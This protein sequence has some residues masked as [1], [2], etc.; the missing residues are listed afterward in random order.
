MKQLQFHRLSE[1]FPMM[2]GEAFESLVADTK[3]RGLLHPIVLHNGKILDGRNRYRACIQADVPIRVEN[4][5]GP[6]PVGFVIASNL[7]RRHLNES[8]RAMVA[9]KLATMP[10]GGSNRPDGLLTQQVTAS[11]LNTSTRSIRRATAV[12]IKGTPE[13]IHRVERGDITVATAAKVAE[14]PKVEQQKLTNAD[15]G[16][17]R[18]AV[19]KARRATRETELAEATAVASRKLGTTLYGVIYADPPW[20]FEPYSTDTGM[21]RAADNHY[22]T[23]DIDRIKAMKVPA[24]KDCV[25][26]LWATV[27]M[28]DV[29]IDVLRA[30][31]F[32]YKSNFVWTKHKAGTGYWNRNRHEI[33]L[34]ATKGKPPAPA[35]G[36]QY[37][38]VV[39][40]MV[41]KHSVKPAV[42]AEMIETMFPRTKLL[43]MFARGS[44]AGWDSW[45]NEA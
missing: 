44:R 20:R 6:D 31:G 36:E 26:F 7:H 24:A 11:M 2:E 1:L 15:E 16:E 9:A 3:E 42:F 37:D 27:P 19:K 33:L 41:G 38:S 13:L 29:A 14:L 12:R 25:L 21:D 30:W 23:E 10:K 22:P 34:I 28:L 39:Q 5:D 18:G 4:F 17:L 40:E 32:A 35:P 8:Q 43:E 45:G